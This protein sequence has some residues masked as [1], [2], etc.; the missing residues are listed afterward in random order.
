MLLGLMLV[1]AGGVLLALAAGD[2]L[3]DTRGALFGGG[4]ADALR[5]SDGSKRLFGIG[6]EDEIRG[7]AGDDE[8]CDGPGRDAVLGGAGDDFVEARD[9]EPDR[10]ACGPGE[11]AASLDEGDAAGSCETLYPG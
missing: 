6:G 9:G 3:A 10:V 5:G 7:L 1:A 8:L 11:D 4:G 2:A